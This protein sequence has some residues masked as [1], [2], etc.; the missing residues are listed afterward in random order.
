[1]NTLPVIHCSAWDC[2]GDYSNLID[3]THTIR[4]VNGTAN[5]TY[6]RNTPSDN[7]KLARVDIARG[8]RI[9]SRYVKHDTQVMLMP[10]AVTIE[11][12]E[13]FNEWREYNPDCRLD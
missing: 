10:L 4:L 1:M 12:L 11:R 9:V 2:V 6:A 8:L 7:V 3:T 5:Y 13:W